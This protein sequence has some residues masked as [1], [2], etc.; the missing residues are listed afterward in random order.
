MEKN[1]DKLTEEQSEAQNDMILEIYNDSYITCYNC[2]TNPQ[3][4]IDFLKKGFEYI[5]CQL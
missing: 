1:L 3:L 2:T 4:P 5:F